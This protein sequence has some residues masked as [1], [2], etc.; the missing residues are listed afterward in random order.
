[1]DFSKRNK[2]VI[3]PSSFC[4]AD[5]APLSTLAQNGFDIIENPYKRKLTKTELL[6]LLSKDASG[7]IAGLEPLDREV[8]QKSKLKVISRCG[9]GISN[10]DIEAAKELG[11]KVYSTPDAPVNAV[12]ELTLAAILGLLRAIP[13]M[14]ND[15]HNGQWKRSIGIQLEGKTIAIIGFGRIGRRLTEI[16]V[17]FRVKI[18][19]S[20]SNPALKY[21]GVT[22][23]PLEQ[24]LP[25]AD[26]VTIHASG[27]GCIIGEKEFGL[28][29][30]GAFLLNA[31]RGGL[32][33]ESALAKALDSGII[34]GAWLDAF[35]SEPYKGQLSAYPQ[36]ILTPHIGSYTRECRIRMEKEAVENLIKGFVFESGGPK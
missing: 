30:R 20:D 21:S 3:G 28:F 2:I 7:I 10:V 8:L 12:A 1:M 11:I 14:S 25:Q 34:R 23:L 27:G 26:I 19:A 4:E 36:V 18:L 32:V 35:E 5:K 29:K 6:E 33:D 24:A 31:A 17:S 15:L 22:F 9:S 13:Q 16:L